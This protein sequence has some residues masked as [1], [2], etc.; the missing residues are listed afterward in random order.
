MIAFTI[1]QA[2]PSQ[3][4]PDRNNKLIFEDIGYLF[5]ANVLSNLLWVPIYRSYNI[6]AW[7]GAFVDITFMLASSIYIMRKA[8]RAKVNDSEIITLRVGFSIYSAWVM[9]ATIVGITGLFKMAGFE[10][11]NIPFGLD[12]EQVAIGVLWIAFLIYNAIAFAERNPLFGAIFIWVIF[13]IG[14]ESESQYQSLITNTTILGFMQIFMMVGLT[15][16]ILKK[17][18]PSSSQQT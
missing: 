7:I 6:Y 2:M 11:P 16:Y 17:P 10:D 4:V 15:I 12:E 8:T 1:Y 9:A 13:S 14:N 5:M 3:S 18:L